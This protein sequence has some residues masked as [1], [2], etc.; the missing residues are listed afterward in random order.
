MLSYEPLPPTLRTVLFSLGPFKY[1]EKRLFSKEQEIGQQSMHVLP[2][3][4]T[5]LKKFH[6]LYQKIRMFTL[7]RLRRCKNVYLSYAGSL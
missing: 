4:F 5:F 3:L 2:G 7:D 1:L 6:E